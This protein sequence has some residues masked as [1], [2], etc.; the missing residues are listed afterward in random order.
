[1]INHSSQLY[2]KQFA[3][4]IAVMKSSILTS[5][6]I[7]DW[8]FQLSEADKEVRVRQTTA[9]GAQI[10]PVTISRDDAE[11][12]I[13]ELQEALAILFS[14]GASGHVNPRVESDDLIT[15]KELQKELGVS[16]STIDRFFRH[17]RNEKIGHISVPLHGKSDLY[18][19]EE[20]RGLYRIFVSRNPRQTI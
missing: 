2:L 12:F 11:L 15:R 1:M 10:I 5:D 17:L 20:M 14:K 6:E 19:C 18:S 3:E 13:S 16:E 4:L 8:L 9:A 7:A